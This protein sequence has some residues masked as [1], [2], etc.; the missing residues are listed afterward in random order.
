MTTD[1]TRDK[2]QQDGETAKE[3]GE[4]PSNGVSP[5]QNDC[6]PRREHNR[7]LP[8]KRDAPSLGAGDKLALLADVS[9]AIVEHDA[10]SKLYD[11][12]LRSF[13]QQDQETIST[14]GSVPSSASTNGCALIS[15]EDENK[16]E[17][18]DNHVHRPPLPPL[19][20]NVTRKKKRVQFNPT[21]DSAVTDRYE[22]ARAALRHSFMQAS[23]SQGHL[24]GAS[25]VVSVSTAGSADTTTKHAKGVGRCN[26]W[27]ES[28]GD[29]RH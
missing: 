12:F 19:L 17:S 21:T 5:K 29:F 11:N 16:Q 28:C 23:L 26:N 2:L 10:R 14:R 22:S 6:H 7:L 18:R 25:E 3:R 27:R 13:A 9:V 20:I 4:C 1:K 8:A 15:G 24:E